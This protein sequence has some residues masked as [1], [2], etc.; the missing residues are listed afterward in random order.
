MGCQSSRSH[1]YHETLTTFTLRCFQMYVVPKFVAGTTGRSL[2]ITQLMWTKPLEY[3][4]SITAQTPTVSRKY[5]VT[6][7]DCVYVLPGYA[8]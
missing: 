6:T 7:Q 2:K 4:L 1:L 5:A 8:V 3:Q